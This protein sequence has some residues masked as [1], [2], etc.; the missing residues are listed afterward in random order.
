MKFSIK[1][2]FSKCD[3]MWPNPPW[4]LDLVTFTGEIINGKLHFLCSGW[5]QNAHRFLNVFSLREANLIIRSAGESLKKTDSTNRFNN[6]MFF[7]SSKEIKHSLY[8]LF[9]RK[10]HEHQLQALFCYFHVC[11]S[12]ILS[13]NTIICSFFIRTKTY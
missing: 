2:F 3:Q 12:L 7:S 1:D 10:S 5:F 11:F 9:N 6:N 13:D 8:T 4:P